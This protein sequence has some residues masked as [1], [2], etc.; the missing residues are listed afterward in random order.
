MKYSAMMSFE[1]RS[2]WRSEKLRAHF[3]DA[4][5]AAAVIALAVSMSLGILRS[6][7]A[8]EKDVGRFWLQ[9]SPLPAPATASTFTKI[10][11]TAAPA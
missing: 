10:S 9:P 3:V 6:A 8:A 4:L 1:H 11:T 5:L 7:N 2:L